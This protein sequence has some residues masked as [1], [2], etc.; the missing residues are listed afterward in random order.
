MPVKL[1]LHIAAYPETYLFSFCNSS[2]KTLSHLFLTCCK[3]N[4]VERF[5]LYLLFI[6]TEYTKSMMT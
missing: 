2:E 6:I 3:L 1:K 4:T 5:I